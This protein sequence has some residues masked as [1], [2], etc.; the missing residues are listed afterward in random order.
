MLANLSG[1]NF[2][3]INIFVC[4]LL[5]V[6][7]EE[8]INNDCTVE[9]GCLNPTIQNYFKKTCP[10]CDKVALN[11]FVNSDIEQVIFVRKY[12]YDFAKKCGK[13]KLSF[14]QKMLFDESCDYLILANNGKLINYIKGD[15]FTPSVAEPNPIAIIDNALSL[16]EKHLLNQNINPKTKLFIKNSDILWIGDSNLLFLNINSKQQLSHQGFACFTDFTYQSP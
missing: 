8:I 10:Q 9:N 5:L 11:K 4:C 3:I 13:L 12:Q 14:R 7:C 2:A 15:C 16:E 1:K 6:G